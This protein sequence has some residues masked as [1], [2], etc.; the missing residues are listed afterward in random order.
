MPEPIEAEPTTTATTEPPKPG[1]TDKSEKP[2]TDW[3]AEARKW[4]TRAKEN[5]TAAAKLAEIEEAKKS[6]EQRLEERATAAEKLAAD[7]AL[8]AARATIALDKGLTASQA[9]RLVGTTEEELSA[10]ADEL[11]ADLGT[12]TSTS[13]R[14]DHSQ[15]PKSTV[16]EQTPQSSFAAALQ[17]AVRR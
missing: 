12:K 11:L 10:D 14:A 7:R 15:G 9:K 13:P 4:E 1:P 2:E 16:G 5:S 8:D 6:N 3:K 17:E